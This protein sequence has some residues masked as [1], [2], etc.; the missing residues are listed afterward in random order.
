[1]PLVFSVPKTP[2]K[3]N[4]R[5]AIFRI[6]ATFWRSRKRAFPPA[7]STRKPAPTTVF[8]SGRLSYRHLHGWAS[9]AFQSTSIPKPGRSLIE[10][11]GPRISSGSFTT[12]TAW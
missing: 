9:T 11:K 5:I 10:I 7:I 8:G 12:E 6:I 1:M 3:R 4:K 2:S